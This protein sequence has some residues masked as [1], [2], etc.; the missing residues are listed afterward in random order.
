MARPAAGSAIRSQRRVIVGL[1]GNDH[2]LNSRQQL[3]ALSQ[4]QTQVGDI[5]KTTRPADLCHIE[6][7][8]L[9]IDAG[10]NQQQNPLHRQ[11][12][13]NMLPCWPIVT[14]PSLSP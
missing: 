9:T 12:P 13:S 6:A 1:R 10:S 8:G 5:A 4:R 14:L 2:L 3:L 11:T 7:S